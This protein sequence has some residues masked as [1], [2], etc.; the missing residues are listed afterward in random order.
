MSFWTSMFLLLLVALLT[1]VGQVTFKIAALRDSTLIKKLTWAPFLIGLT[2][3]LAGP[4]LANLASQAVPFSLLYAMTSLNFVFILIFA[5]SI[6]GEPID[7]RKI[8]GVATIVAG[9]V[10]MVS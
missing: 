4:V 2:C 5:R 3:F 7:A 8:A 9:L 6:L 10:L 1:G